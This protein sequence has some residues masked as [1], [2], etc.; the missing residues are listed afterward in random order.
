MRFPRSRAKRAHEPAR[1]R[2]RPQQMRG[3]HESGEFVGWHRATSLRALAP[4][5]HDL[6]IIDDFVEDA[7]QIIP[8]ASYM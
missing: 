8:Q 4:H 1:I 6:A 3:F 7:R 2:G 5:D